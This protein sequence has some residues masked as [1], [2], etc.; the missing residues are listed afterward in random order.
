MPEVRFFAVHDWEKLMA[1]YPDY[2]AGALRAGHV[3]YV[4]RDYMREIAHWLE[5]QEAAAAGK[6][7]HRYFEH[8]G[9]GHY[10]KFTMRYEKYTEHILRLRAQGR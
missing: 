4:L 9:A 2:F 1:H 7:L 6:W 8:F 5:T 3:P 10:E